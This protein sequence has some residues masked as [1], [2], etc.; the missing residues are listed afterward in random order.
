VTYD[1]T[2]S[3]LYDAEGRIC[4]VNS[5]LNLMSSSPNY[6]EYIYDASGTRVAEGT[7]SSWPTACVAPT[8]AN[9]FTLTKSWVLGP[10]GEQV[11]EYAVSNGTSTWN[12]TNA[13]ADSGL[14]ATYT[15]TNN[16]TIFDL[17]DWLGTKRVEVGASG[18][19]TT[20]RSLP[21]GDGLTTVTSSNPCPDATEH[22]Y[23]GKEQDSESGNDYFGARYYASSMGRWLSPDPKMMSSLK[24]LKPQEWNMYSYAG[25]EPLSHFDPDGRETKVYTEL[26]GLGHTFVVIN[27]AQHDVLF[28]YGRYAGGSSGHNWHGL[29]PT[30]PGILI[31]IEGKDNIDKFVADRAK[32]DPTLKGTTVSVPNEEKE[33]QSFEARFDKGAKLTDAET[34]VLA[35]S[36][37]DPNN[38]RQVEDFNVLWNNCTTTTNDGLRAGGADVDWGT[39]S[40]SMERDFLTP[41][42]PDLY[43]SYGDNLTATQNQN[44]TPIQQQPAP[45]P[46]KQ[47]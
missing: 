22:H 13:W 25:N 21:F 8:V 17:Q 28:S 27:N 46:N 32:K 5:K 38:A 39:F 12:H 10:S 4:A 43:S 37:I 23:T 29:S 35:N 1:G 47:P 11:T 7:L 16:D 6:Y 31:R 44:S 30:G 14:L 20:F 19:I 45:T 15:I 18:C 3:Y 41:S 2:N 33:F 42:M 9:G 36:P 26:G 40:P 34:K 24:M